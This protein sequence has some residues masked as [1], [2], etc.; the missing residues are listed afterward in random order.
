MDQARI[1]ASAG[2]T[3]T[4]ANHVHGHRLGC[5]QIHPRCG[6]CAGLCS[7]VGSRCCRSSRRTCRTMPPPVPVAARLTGAGAAG[8]RGRRRAI[9]PHEP[10]A[11]EAE[12]DTGAQ[13]IVQ[14]QRFGI[15]ARSTTDPQGDLAAAGAGQLRAAG[16][17]GRHH[18]RRGGGQ[19]GRDQSASG[20]Y[21]QYGVRA[22][23]RRACGAD[24]ATSTGAA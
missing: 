18:P 7:G 8:A 4:P 21:R 2:M 11:A 13:V 22:G 9:R 10:G 16:G 12:S 3:R 24:S 19:S 1:R 5:R 23:G 20:R 6:A 17:R 14:G 15:C